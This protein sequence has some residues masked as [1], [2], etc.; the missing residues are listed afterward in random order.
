M[1]TFSKNENILR[2]YINSLVITCAVFKTASEYFVS[3][4][5]DHVKNTPAIPVMR[6]ENTVYSK[7]YISYF[8]Y[9]IVFVITVVFVVFI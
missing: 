1:I 7:V 9:L 4:F 8:F 3:L 5:T 2:H 6:S